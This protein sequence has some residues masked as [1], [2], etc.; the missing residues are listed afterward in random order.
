MN[1]EE[2][3]F[4]LSPKYIDFCNTINNVDIDIL[5][6]TTASGKTTI[7][8]GIKFM[9]MISMSNKK[10]HIIAARTVGVAEKNIINQDNGILDIH[11]NA[12]Y[13]GNGDKDHK[14][15]HI[16]FENKIIYVLSYKNKDQWENALGG[17]Y[18]CVYIDEGN[19]ANI[20]FIREIITR[21]DYMC[22][23]LNPDD[24]NLS[25]YEEVI[26]HARPYKKY[27]NDV[28]AEIM[29]ELNKVKLIKNYR[30]WFFTF[31]D[32]KGLTEEE[33][34]K[35][36]TV[37]PVGTKLYKNKIQ[38]LRGKATG[39][40]FNLESKNIITVEEARKLKFQIFS[41]GCDTSYSKESHDKVTLEGIGITTDGKCVLLK[42]RTFNNKDRTIPFAPS[43]VVQWIVEFME[44]FK[45]EWGFARTCFIDNADQGTIMEAKKAKRQ[46]NLIYNFENAWKK[47]KI[48]TRVQLQE[49]WLGTSDFLVVETCKDYIE[50][51]GVYSF[52]ENNQPEDGNDHSINGCQYA[53]LPYKKKIGNWEIIKKII[54]DE[55]EE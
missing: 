8:A 54:K 13:C 48:I 26:N 55:S 20:D 38:G 18:G 32:N 25:I 7:A 33:I 52:D 36:K 41:I 42:E 15:P 23:T 44:E 30:Y 3:E 29:K 17:Q 10:E 6:G 21:N 28:P 9:R 24:P 34:E 14:F 45:N 1:N 53:W 47:T 16:K 39:L 22:I 27:A 51:C 11:K 50:E 40:C 31:Y 2:I 49:S 46:N 4:E 37:A 43:D 12:I 19:T 5:E 35:K